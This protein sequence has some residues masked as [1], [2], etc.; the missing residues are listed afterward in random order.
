MMGYFLAFFGLVL[1]L[2]LSVFVSFFGLPI[3]ISFILLYVP[4]GYN[5]SLVIGLIPA[6]CTRR[7]IVRWCSPDHSAISV[8]VSPSMLYIIEYFYKNVKCLSKKTLLL[9]RCG[10]KNAKILLFLKIFSKTSCISV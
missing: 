10:A 5:A 1:G 2:G 7:S 3:L 9:Y 4:M 8:K 6:R